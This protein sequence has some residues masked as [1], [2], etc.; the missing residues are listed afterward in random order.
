MISQ[1]LCCYHGPSLQVIALIQD[2]LMGSFMIQVDKAMI[3][4][5]QEA[6][7]DTE[8]ELLNTQK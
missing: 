3:H 1:K 7:I 2:L 6:L 8:F 4:Q 5:L